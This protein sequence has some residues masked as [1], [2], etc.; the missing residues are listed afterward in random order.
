MGRVDWLKQNQKL[1]NV[2]NLFSFLNRK[3]VRAG[4][5]KIPEGLKKAKKIQLLKNKKQ[6]EVLESRPFPGY[7]QRRVTI[8]VK[9]QQP[10]P[11]GEGKIKKLPR[12]VSIVT[13]KQLKIRDKCNRTH[14]KFTGGQRIRLTYM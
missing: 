4:K 14:S 2:L 7:K 1:V 3:D 5:I 6:C 9:M 13:Q 12:K 11:D 8:A 10:P